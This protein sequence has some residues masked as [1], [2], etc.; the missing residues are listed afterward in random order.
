MLAHIREY[1]QHRMHILV[2][3]EYYFN[4]YI[5][6][7]FYKLSSYYF[8]K[9]SSATQYELVESETR[10]CTSKMHPKQNEHYSEICVNL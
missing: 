6:N 7:F 4:I 2:S 1:L 5:L 10:I 3:T 9:L 8:Q